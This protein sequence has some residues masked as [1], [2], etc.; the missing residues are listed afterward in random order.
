MPNQQIIEKIASLKQRYSDPRRAAKL[1]REAL[2]GHYPPL[3]QWD[4]LR[5]LPESYTDPERSDRETDL[6]FAAPIAENEAMV[7]VYFDLETTNPEA[8]ADR[9][10]SCMKRIEEKWVERHGNT[11]PLPVILPVLMPVFMA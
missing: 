4:K 6:L 9:L 7:Y 3:I 10:R 2:S 1:F 5:L 8:A 11:K